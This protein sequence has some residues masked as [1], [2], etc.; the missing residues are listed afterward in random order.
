MP[1]LLPP[2]HTVV[3]MLTSAVLNWSQNES[4]NVDISTLKG[5]DVVIFWGHAR[6]QS[7]EYWRCALPIFAKTCMLPV[8]LPTQ[9]ALISLSQWAW[10]YVPKRWGHSKGQ[11]FKKQMLGSS[12]P[13][14]GTFEKTSCTPRW[15]IAVVSFCS[16]K[17]DQESLRY[18]P[19]LAHYFNIFQQFST[20]FE[21]E[22][23]SG[24]PSLQGDV[25]FHLPP[26]SHLACRL[27]ASWLLQ[28][29]MIY[30]V[31]IN[32]HHHH[33]WFPLIPWIKVS[34][35][36]D[37]DWSRITWRL[38]R[39]DTCWK[40]LKPGKVGGIRERLRRLVESKAG[41]WN[42][43]IEM[44]SY[45]FNTHYGSLWFIMNHYDHYDI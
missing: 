20:F 11:F 19:S 44:V 9:A 16:K 18:L 41:K 37:Q 32:L 45:R 35:S 8:H 43:G 34:R 24:F 28:H 38:E 25:G 13:D 26:S 39:F 14:A 23:E 7:L 5:L 29:V 42:Q 1:G 10:M 2:E 21:F 15:K 3:V 22:D 27:A 4:R 40:L 6:D 31:E 17:D 33:I 36:C 12:D 30:Y